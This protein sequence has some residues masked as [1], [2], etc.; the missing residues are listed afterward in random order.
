MGDRPAQLDEPPE[1]RQRQRRAHA[2]AVHPDGIGTAHDREQVQ[3]LRQRMACGGERKHGVRRDHQDMAMPQAGLAQQLLGPHS[4][5][6]V[7]E[8]RLQLADDETR[9]RPS[10]PGKRIR[11]PKHDPPQDAGPAD[12]ESRGSRSRRIEPALIDKIADAADVQGEPAIE[13]RIMSKLG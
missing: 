13:H 10:L 12:R 8:A 7:A 2:V 1:H 9:K 4:A 5:V 11:L 3:I 6:A